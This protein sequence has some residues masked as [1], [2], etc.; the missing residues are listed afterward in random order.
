[1]KRRNLMLTATAVFLLAAC[2]TDPDS[3]GGTAG[4]S[5]GASG[6]GDMGS[7]QDSAVNGGGNSTGG[8]A[9]EPVPGGELV[10]GGQ[11]VPGGELVPGGQ[12]VPGGELAPGGQPVP[13]G[14]P[15]PGG[16]P[17]PGG[18]PVPG[19][20]VADA[21]CPQVGAANCAGLCVEGECQVICGGDCDENHACPGNAVCQDGLCMAVACA[22]PAV[23]EPVCGADGVTYGNACEAQ[24]ADVVVASE[25]ECVG[26]ACPDPN[27]PAV[28]YVSDDPAMCALVRFACAANQEA[29]FGE[30]GCGCIDVEPAC[31][32]PDVFLPVC[33]ADGV[34]YGNACEAACERVVVASEGECGP[35]ICGLP[36]D[37]GQCRGLFPSFGFNSDSG[38]CV[39]FNYGGC[40]GN[41]NRF[42][43]MVECEASCERANVCPSPNDPNVHYVSMDPAFCAAARIVCPEGQRFFSTPE[44]G[45]GCIGPDPVAVQ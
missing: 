33:G 38:Q 36:I 40:E 19:G 43:T 8:A 4:G 34:T 14:E 2:D 39:A 9:G 1:M 25:G 37:A 30:C 32:C 35:G 28:H 45:C 6:E 31:V 17:V 42:G 20:C 13:G 26:V 7:T 24:C 23:F 15:A 11:P 16:Q 10:P 29:F 22:C 18:E 12:P 41:A 21:E 44:C 5:G 27:D 3:T